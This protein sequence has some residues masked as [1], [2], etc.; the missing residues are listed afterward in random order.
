[1]AVLIIA[2]LLLGLLPVIFVLATSVMIGRVPAA[3][4]GGVGSAERQ[5]LVL[6][7]MLAAAAFVVQQIL[8]PLQVSLGELLSRR[9]DGAWAGLPAALQSW[10]RTASRRS[11]WRI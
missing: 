4:T 8:A 7:F 5:A 10:S 3:V 9:I 2:N 6:A 11:G 1:V